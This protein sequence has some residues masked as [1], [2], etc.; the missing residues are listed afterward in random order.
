MG[1]FSAG[2]PDP[3]SILSREELVQY[4]RSHYGCQP[5]KG[6]KRQLLE[7]AYAYHRQERQHG[8]LKASVRKQL[9]KLARADVEQGFNHSSKPR[10]AAGY[11]LVR[12]W[13]GQT[14]VV[15]VVAD[16]FV[17]QGRAYTSLSAI[18]TEITGSRWSGPRF[19]GL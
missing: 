8:C 19:F 13:Q 6:I 4:W 16:G 18:A 2:K 10:L 1:G 3:A 11:R 7:R 15:D 5:P 12:E 14:H 9:L 17:W